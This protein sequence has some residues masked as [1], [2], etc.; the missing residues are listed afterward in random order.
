M[1]PYRC[2]LARWPTI[3][4]DRDCPTM[5]NH[6]EHLLQVDRARILIDVTRGRDAWKRGHRELGRGEW[7]ERR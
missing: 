1:P 7:Q 4:E 2:S 5:G 6:T 3:T